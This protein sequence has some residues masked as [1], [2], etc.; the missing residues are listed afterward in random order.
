MSK[1]AKGERI[2]QSK[3]K[4]YQIKKIRERF[5]NGE[6]YADLAKDYKVTTVNI[7]Y[8]VRRKNWKHVP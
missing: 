5:K 2:K 6:N 8:I 1:Q 4:Q 7:G 3:L